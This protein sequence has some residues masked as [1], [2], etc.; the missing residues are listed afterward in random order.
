MA[1]PISCRVYRS[2][3]K[4]SKCANLPGHGECTVNTGTYTPPRR[5][6]ALMRQPVP[7]RGNIYPFITTGNGY[8]I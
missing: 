8:I 2:Q 3:V 7:K 5:T 6:V 4:R 1:K